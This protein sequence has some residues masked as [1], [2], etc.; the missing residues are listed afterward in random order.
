MK[1]YSPV[2]LTATNTKKQTCQLLIIFIVQVIMIN[3][4]KVKL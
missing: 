4:G 1:Y 2:P 3:E